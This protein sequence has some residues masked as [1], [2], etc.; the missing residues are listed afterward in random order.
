MRARKKRR[1]KQ[2]K[3]RRSGLVGGI[4]L[5]VLIYG[6]LCIARAEPERNRPARTKYY[7]SIEVAY[8]DTLWEIAGRYRSEEYATVEEYMREVMEMNHLTDGQI[9]AGS[10]LMV[11]YYGDAP[12]EELLD[13]PEAAG[14]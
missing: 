13:N 4:V 1:V 10:H 6:G 14:L 5:A 8:G 9:R 11:A 7:T 3:M 12:M 2:S